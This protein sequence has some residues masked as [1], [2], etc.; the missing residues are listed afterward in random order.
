MLKSYKKEPV[1]IRMG[2]D[3]HSKIDL[4]TVQYDLSRSEFINQCVDYALEHMPKTQ[5]S[6]TPEV[7]MVPPVLFYWRALRTISAK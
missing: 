1:P 7:L 3:K 6:K 2:T 5:D 4:L